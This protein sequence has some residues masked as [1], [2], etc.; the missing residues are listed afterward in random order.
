MALSGEI[1]AERVNKEV[2]VRIKWSATQDIVLNQSTV[3]MEFWVKIP[4][5]VGK[6]KD[7]FTT[8]IGSDEATAT[9][10]DHFVECPRG[11]NLM[12]TR[13]YVVQHADD[14][15]GQVFMW[16]NAHFNNSF[17]DVHIDDLTATA[18]VQLDQIARASTI[19]SSTRSVA[20]GGTYS[21]SVARKST[22]FTHKATIWLLDESEENTIAATKTEKTF[23]TQTSFNVPEDWMTYFTN[24]SSRKAKVSV[25]TY[26]G[27]TAIGSPV[28]TTFTV[29][30]PST[31]APTVVSGWATQDVDNSGIGIAGKDLWLQK[32]SKALVEIKTNLIETKYGA[33][34]EKVTATVSGKTA[35]MGNDGKI[36]LPVF[37]SYGKMQISVTVTDTRGLTL[38]E[39]LPEITV[40]QYK[41]PTLSGVRIERCNSSGAADDEGNYIAFK[42]TANWCDSRA[43][44][45]INADWKL[46]SASSWG[47]AV[48]LTSGTQ[49]VLGNGLI[50]ETSSYNA[51][52]RAEDAVGG[53]VSTEVRIGTASV[54]FNCRDGGN[55]AA[56]GK[57]AETPNAFEM[58]VGWVL[59]IG[60]TTLTEAQLQSLI[61]KI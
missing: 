49:S 46:V 48:S 14:G 29:T 10:E 40:V 13:T 32:Y 45:T 11:D 1:V 26:N 16:A 36:H 7:R 43:A 50:S 2:V 37:V 27:G 42:A 38:T 54:V 22:T 57:Y 9:K 44:G 24:A 60:D 5:S 20:A 28:T 19:A 21:L 39:K 52:I 4:S 8:K 6:A 58:P 31:A 33:G 12:G 30:A 55:G 15:T 59:K 25:Q 23:V 34:I 41:A 3:R 35:Q 51:R 18:T 53:T 17:H 47:T 56:V 61:A